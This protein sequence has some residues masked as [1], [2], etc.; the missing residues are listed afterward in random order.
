MSHR[1]HQAA[2]ASA[3][4]TGDT[5]LTL[6][7]QLGN[8][9]APTRG[10][11]AAFGMARQTLAGHLDDTRLVNRTLAHLRETTRALVE[12]Q[13]VIAIRAG[14]KQAA[15]E[16]AV[17]DD[18]TY[19]DADTDALLDSILGTLDAELDAQLAK[20]RALAMHGDE[21]LILG[22]ATNVLDAGRNGILRASDITASAVGWI[23]TGAVLAYAAHIGQ[24]A[25]ASKVEWHKQAV[26]A[27]DGRTTDC[28]LR[29]SGQAVP[30]D[31]K[32]QL[33]GTPRYADQLDNPPFHWN[34]RTATAL[35]RASDAGDDLTKRMTDAAQAEL[36]ARERGDTRGYSRYINAFSGREGEA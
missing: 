34:C 19:A 30:L 24:A 23:A 35:V 6:F 20:V 12:K 2:L 10:V 22:D 8:R 7:D 29:V 15:R 4:K 11:W 18:L 28:C 25:D 5:L 31:E 13:I 32:F 17:Y 9:R 36:Y 33:D 21:T 1:E 16:I 26:A 3:L 14:E 27:I